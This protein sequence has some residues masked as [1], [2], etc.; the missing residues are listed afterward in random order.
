MYEIFHGKLRLI[1][2]RD[3]VVERVYEYELRFV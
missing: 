3:I 1:E 2:F